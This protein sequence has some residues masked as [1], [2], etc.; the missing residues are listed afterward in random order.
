[1]K[2]PKVKVYSDKE[3]LIATVLD[4]YSKHPNYRMSQNEYVGLICAISQQ[5][6]SDI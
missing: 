3:E 6:M 2:T 5:M 4:F 1:M